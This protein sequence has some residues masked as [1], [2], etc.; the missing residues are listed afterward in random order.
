MAI[1]LTLLLYN[2]FTYFAFSLILPLLWFISVLQLWIYTLIVTFPFLDSL[3]HILWF[4]ESFR[5]LLFNFL[6]SFSTA[7]TLPFY[8]FTPIQYCYDILLIYIYIHI[9]PHSSSVFYFESPPLPS[10]LYYVSFLLPLLW[11]FILT[12]NSDFLHS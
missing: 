4:I 11:P 2:Y 5:F 1:T 8:L 12:F 9:Q 10:S 3:F 6:I 7:M